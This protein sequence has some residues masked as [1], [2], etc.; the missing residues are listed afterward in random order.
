[1]PK[2]VPTPRPTSISTG[3][4]GPRPARPGRSAAR[5]APTAGGWSFRFG[6]R[7]CRPCPQRGACM[8]STDLSRSRIIAVHPEPVHTARMAARQAQDSDAWKKTYNVRAGIEG[9]ISQAVRGPGLRHSR[10]RGMPKAHLQN[11]LTGIAI[12]IS[13]LGDH[14]AARPKAPRRPTHIHELFIANHITA[15]T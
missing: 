2:P 8:T 13:R 4:P 3:P 7:D 9:T 14:F 6:N 5:C 1:M 11:V 15:T 12:N 10:Y